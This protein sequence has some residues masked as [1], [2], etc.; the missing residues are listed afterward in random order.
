MRVNAVLLQV[1]QVEKKKKKKKKMETRSM[2]LKRQYAEVEAGT[3]EEPKEVEASTSEEP[4]TKK[5][6][7]SEEPATKKP[8]WEESIDMLAIQHLPDLCKE[9]ILK[10]WCMNNLDEFKTYDEVC[11]AAK[12]LHPDAREEF[13]SK[14]SMA[15]AEKR[16]EGHLK[17]VHKHLVSLIF[18]FNMFFKIVCKCTFFL[19][20]F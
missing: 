6:K 1:K 11:N 3:A 7:C 9:V 8:K 5:P 16:V 12:R 10:Q 20:Y 17:I 18:I 15:H 19:F 13:K 2:S 14:W 4:T